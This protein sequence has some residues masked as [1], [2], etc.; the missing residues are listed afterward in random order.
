MPAHHSI[1]PSGLLQGLREHGFHSLDQIEVVLLEGNG[2][3]SV[4]PRI[5]RDDKNAQSKLEALMAVPGYPELCQKVLGESR[6]KHVLEPD[7]PYLPDFRSKKNQ[8]KQEASDA[9][10]A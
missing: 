1:A 8:H 6:G 10:V 9:T 3:M 4:V 7:L 2:R 5:D